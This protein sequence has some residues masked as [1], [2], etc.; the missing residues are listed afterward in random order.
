MYQQHRYKTQ[1]KKNYVRYETISS[2]RGQMLDCNGKKLVTNKPIMNL[3]WHGTGNRRLNEQQRELVQQLASIYPNINCDQDTIN[4]INMAE[5]RNEHTLL[6]QDI[7]FEQLSHIE[8][9]CG[10][11]ENIMIK[12]DFKRYYPHAD[13]ACH[14][15]GYLSNVRADPMGKM[16]LEKKLHNTLQGNDGMLMKTINSFGKKIK[17]QQVQPVKM[18]K[19]I[20]TTL[21]IDIQQ[22]IEKVF[23][24]K[25]K[26]AF[27]IMDPATGAIKA[28]CS[29]PNFD[30]SVFLDPLD[31][32]TWQ[33]LQKEQPFLN[34]AMQCAYPPGSLFKLIT[35]SA[36]LEHNI[37]ASDDTFICKGYTQ[38]GG[39]KYLCNR[40]YGHGKLSMQQ[41]L[42]LSCNP[43]FYE[44]GK[45]IKIDT[46]A[47]YAHRFGL[48]QKTGILFPE[49]NGLMPTTAWKKRNYGER[50]WPG[51]TLSAAIG[52]SYI[53]TTPIQIARMIGSIFTGYLIKPRLL[54]DEH[55]EI[56]PLEIEPNT[57]HFLKDS[58]RSVVTEGTGHRVSRIKD[59]I[60]H[61]KT[62][63]AQMS[64]MKKR[65]LGKQF[66]EHGWVVTHFAYKDQDPLV[67][68][69]LIEHAGSSR[70]PMIIA[71]DFLLGY[72]NQLNT[73]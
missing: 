51:E 12:H 69:I 67:M 11:H 17:T 9:L 3:Y 72:R 19:D 45:K 22:L 58:M 7:S 21:D 26:G 39:R 13:V 1:S 2:A 43:L 30:P 14:V 55:I 5:K 49:K 73:I 61:A 24:N 38:F 41:A 29:R 31:H 64:D 70:V 44:L 47:D 37:I 50:W 42:A 23:S 34:R 20:I 4:A 63:T 40:T 46:L 16:G 54:K 62:S 36:A 6:L 18:G 56:E 57:L 71:K 52:Q 25:H 35:I 53:L 48:G 10:H 15:V 28:L 32:E 59:Y 68:V 60:I 8:E 27:I 66:L 33:S 65:K